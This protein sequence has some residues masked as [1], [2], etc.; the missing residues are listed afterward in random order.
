[1]LAL[2]FECDREAAGGLIGVSKNGSLGARERDRLAE[3]GW[4]TGGGF[5]V[6]EGNGWLC[7]RL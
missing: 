7:D 5:G 2:E 1:M 6:E 4:D 3:A